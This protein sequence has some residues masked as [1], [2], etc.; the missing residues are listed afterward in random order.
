MRMMKKCKESVF[1]MVDV[2]WISE[3][4]SNFASA[5]ETMWFRNADINKVSGCSAVGSALRSGRR[6]RQFESGHP[7]RMEWKVKSEEFKLRLL[8]KISD[9]YKLKF[10]T[11]HFLYLLL[12]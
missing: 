3:F 2:L 7:D 1:F 6:S 4:I 12:D 10:F 11:L 9:N 5:F 8:C